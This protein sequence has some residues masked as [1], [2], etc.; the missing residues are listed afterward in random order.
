[1]S[2]YETDPIA[3]RIR[4]HL[5]FK[6]DPAGGVQEIVVAGGQVGIGK[7]G[8][9]NLVVGV[10]IDA[11]QLNGVLPPYAVTTEL[12]GSPKR[13][14]L[15]IV[16]T[17][18]VDGVH[19]LGRVEFIVLMALIS[20]TI[21]ASIDTI[22]PAFDEM[23]LAFGKTVGDSN[24]SLSITVF[25]AALGIGMLV[26]GPLADA[27][28]RKKTMLASLVIF[29]LGAAISTL[30]S[31]FTVFL[32]GRVIWGAAAAGPRTIGMA[33]T[34][35]S[36]EG[37]TMA[38]VMSFISAVF[39]IV[40]IL[41]PAAGEAVLSFGSWRYTTALGG[42]LGFIAAV[43]FLRINETLDPANVRP[44]SFRPLVAATREVLRSRVAMAFTF[45]TA[46][47]Y[48]A[49]FPWLG[50]SIQMMDNI[51]GQG[52]RFSLYFGLNAV[53]MA[54]AILIVERVVSRV[55]TMPVVW[56]LS[57]AAVIVAAG[58]VV[59]SL[60][61]SGVPGF[62]PWFLVA[63]ILTALNAGANPLIQT[64][65]LE[66]LGDVAGTGSS[67]TGSMIFIS[68]ALIGSIIDG[69]IDATVT[70]FGAGFFVLGILS[71]GAIWIGTRPV[72]E[73]AS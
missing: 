48:G 72:N 29:I 34:R 63:S 69:F 51:Y 28:G 4:T 18:E 13:K 12:A 11:D 36:Y 67:I 38:R 10:S 23:E 30:A 43:W 58:Y 22:L 25:L 49:F 9:G 68:G 5:V 55:G 70:A 54:L 1:M 20:T 45:A 61:S 62:W 2:L 15:D 6:G 52:E 53:F 60:T 37:D 35:D 39:L 14:A 21:A 27:F 44:L 56:T 50:S 24:I 57:V 26:W 16:K 40:P 19:G 47:S 59:M 33:I 42:L 46:M 17:T 66:P 31:N 7:L 8:D 32:I 3:S 73:M 65:S 64:K 41:A 71:L